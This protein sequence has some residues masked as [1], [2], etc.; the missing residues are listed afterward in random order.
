[1]FWL[2]MDEVLL[3]SQEPDLIVPVEDLPRRV[4]SRRQV[5]VG[6]VSGSIWQRVT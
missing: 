2:P 3:S 5:V 6:D 1:M 4:V